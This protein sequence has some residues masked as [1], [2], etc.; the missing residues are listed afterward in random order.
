MVL[1]SIFL[2][3]LPVAFFVYPYWL[4]QH[5]TRAVEAKTYGMTLLIFALMI[6][7]GYVAFYV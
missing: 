7:S 4:Q 6:L 5:S 2:G 1:F 3:L